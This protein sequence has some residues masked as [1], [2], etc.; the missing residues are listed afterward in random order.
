MN[1]FDDLKAS[2]EDAVEIKQGR[3]AAGRVTRHE[4]ADVKAIRARLAVSQA[5]FAKAMGTSVDTIKS[6]EGRRRN[7]TGLA[8]KVLAAIQDNPDFY[9]ELATH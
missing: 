8:A 9:R 3:K 1:V 5:E 4:V 7:P 6:W 2:L